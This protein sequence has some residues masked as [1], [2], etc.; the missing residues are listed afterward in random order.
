M[1]PVGTARPD[2][3]IPPDDCRDD[4]EYDRRDEPEHEDVLGHR[5]VD[6]GNRR[7]VNQ[8]MV[9]RAVGDVTDD[10]FAGV[11]PT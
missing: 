9:E 2:R 4:E 11:E 10:R 6:S 8:R 5:E 1:N 7:Q 3:Q